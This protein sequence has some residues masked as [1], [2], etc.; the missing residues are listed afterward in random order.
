MSHGGELYELLV[1]ARKAHHHAAHV[2]AKTKDPARRK[3]AADVLD[4]AAIAMAF[5]A[6]QWGLWSDCAAPAGTVGDAWKKR[7][8]A[9]LFG[10]PES[11]PKK[12]KR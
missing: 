6:A 12:T 1:A 3:E 4:R 9:E 8:Y 7:I 11:Q 10:P 2:Y 5:A